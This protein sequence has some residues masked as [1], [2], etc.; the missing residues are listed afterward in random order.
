MS[1]DLDETLITLSISAA[2]N[3]TAQA[4]MGKLKDLTNC[5]VHLSHIPTPGDKAGLKC[6]GIHLTSEPNFS[7]RDLF[8]T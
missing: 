1:L 2:T 3:P 7:S 5:D 8:Q 6:L 4:A